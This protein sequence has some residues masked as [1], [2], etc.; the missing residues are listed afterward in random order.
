MS[1]MIYPQDLDL[2]RHAVGADSKTPG[3]RNYF[4]AADCDNIGW[5]RLTRAGLAEYRGPVEHGFWYRVTEAGCRAIGLSKAA[6]R[7]AME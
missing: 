6:I 4:E 1:G 5:L 2:L 3:Y 7:R